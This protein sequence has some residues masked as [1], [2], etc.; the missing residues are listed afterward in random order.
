MN[1]V[2]ITTHNTKQQLH[3]IF[4]LTLFIG[5]SIRDWFHSTISV[6]KCRCWQSKIYYIGPILVILVVIREMLILIPVNQEFWFLMLVN[7]AQDPPFPTLCNGPQRSTKDPRWSK[8]DP[9]H[10]PRTQKNDPKR[11][12]KDFLL[13]LFMWFAPPMQLIW[14]PGTWPH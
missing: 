8:H 2:F 7:C 3:L 10:T 13:F 6:T 5:G 14:S 12:L 9:K 11:T 4:K 1:S